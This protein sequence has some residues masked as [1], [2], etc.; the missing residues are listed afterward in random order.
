MN[1][2]TILT[3]MADA[4]TAAGVMHSY[5]APVMATLC[6]F[7][8]LVSVFFLILGGLH[9]MTSGGKPDNLDQAKRTIRNA[10]VGLVIVL[11]AGV[12]TT[13]LSSAYATHGTSTGGQLPTLTELRPTPVSNGLI[14]VL[15][16]AITGLLNNIVQ[17]IAQ[18]FLHAL[19]FFTTAT[20]LMADDSGVF[21]LWLT[22]VAIADGAFVL[23]VALLGFHI[24]SG[25]SFGLDEIEFK[26]LL[27]RLAGIFL[28]VNTSIFAIDGIIEL[29][30][31]MVQAVNA[32]GGS[33]SVWDVLTTVVQGSGGLGV[34]A[35]L[36]MVVFLIFAAILLVYYVGRLVTLYIGAVLSPVV[37][38]LWL[39][40]GFRDFSESAA[41][42][43]VT[44]VFVLFVHVI[45]LQLAAS[46][47][48]GLVATSPDHTPD[49]LMAM[50]VG[51]AT[52]IA[53]LKTQGVMTQLSYVS[54]GPRTAR[55]LGGQFMTGVSY[56]SGKGRFA[57]AAGATERSLSGSR[58]VPG[59]ASAPKQSG[60]SGATV[61]N[62]LPKQGNGGGQTVIRGT[63]SAK[64]NR[65]RTGETTVALKLKPTT[66]KPSPSFDPTNIDSKG[67]DKP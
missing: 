12:L 33:A 60:S 57:T 40:P 31:A 63:S 13:V 41:K 56:L 11:G 18:P 23:V 43:Y 7:A 45:I 21:N 3:H 36:I 9:Y 29:S 42:V 52:L 5:V 26:H 51:L 65:V 25:A 32:T 24:M 6:I 17:S 14:D 10:L 27:P 34:A 2:P 50:V 46:L 55:K 1:A 67:K 44:T 59:I 30:D 8:S 22:M 53:L 61:I 4:N 64:T 47:F 49:T 37:L 20:P 62:R 58:L 39:V 38:L 35:L 19:S 66:S 16:K 28:L 54:V 15:I 48:A